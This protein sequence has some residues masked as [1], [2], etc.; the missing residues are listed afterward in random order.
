MTREQFI[1]FLKSDK[2]PFKEDTENGSD[3][4]YVYSK[5][6]YEL[7]QK[8]PRKYKNLYIPY[9]RV[10][11]FDGDRWYVREDGYCSYMCKSAVIDKCV[12]L[13]EA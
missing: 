9:I 8:H 10:S 11:N 7:K 6:E 4:V 1:T 13:G 5:L 2:I 3:M 12:Q